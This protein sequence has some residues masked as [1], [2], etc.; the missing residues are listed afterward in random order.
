MA[1]P[2]PK[3]Q[4]V[5]PQRVLA[6]RAM[7][8]AE[9]T[10]V[11]GEFCGTFCNHLAMMRDMEVKRWAAEIGGDFK[12]RVDA[13]D[14]EEAVVTRTYDIA[15]PRSATWSEYGDDR[16]DE[17]MSDVRRRALAKHVG[18]AVFGS[19][20]P[21]EDKL[22]ITLLRPEAL[23]QKF[24]RQCESRAGD[25][26]NYYHGEYSFRVPGPSK[27]VSKWLS[28]VKHV[29]EGDGG[30]AQLKPCKDPSCGSTCCLESFAC[31]L[32]RILN[33]RWGP[34]VGGCLDDDRC[35]SLE[36]HGAG[37][38]GELRVRILRGQPADGFYGPRTGP[39][40]EGADVEINFYASW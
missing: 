25:G 35:A 33:H 5:A 37:E 26:Y 4:R 19:G 21:Q 11:V 2:A 1:D 13:A 14:L 36:C 23:V 20:G 24:M 27:L 29:W 6:T 7:L 3:R 38:E 28:P 31:E 10:G 16:L 9:C 39:P 34:T 18:Q 32:K 8:P 15:I 12:K 22:C 40:P 17:F 30:K